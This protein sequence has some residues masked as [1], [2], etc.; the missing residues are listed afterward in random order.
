MLTKSAAC[1]QKLTDTFRL[2]NI[3]DEPQRLESQCLRSGLKGNG[4][5]TKPKSSDCEF[6]VHEV[7]S[8]RT[9]VLRYLLELTPETRDVHG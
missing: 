3:T 7:R 6:S 4:Y 1:A 8:L 5:R 9:E 2:S